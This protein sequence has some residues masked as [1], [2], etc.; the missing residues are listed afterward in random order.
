MK[1]RCI[2]LLI[3]I[4]L[5]LFGQGCVDADVEKPETVIVEP[6]LKVTEVIEIIETAIP[7][8]ATYAPEQTPIPENQKW[9]STD[10]LNA[11]HSAGL[12]AEGAHPM[13]KD[14]YGVAPMIATEGTRFYI[15]SL[16]ADCGG[17]IFSFSSLDDLEILKAFYVEMG[18]GS[19]LFFSWVFDNDNILVQINGDLPEE[20]AMLYDEA[21]SGLGK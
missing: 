20:E 12:E 1:I 9:V 13:T 4:F 10:V 17:R 14:D 21:L 6:E 3:L 11:F 16:C 7:Q 15:P 5:V 18:K 8:P 19:A 2:T